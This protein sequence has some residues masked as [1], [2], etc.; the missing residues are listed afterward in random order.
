VGARTGVPIDVDLVVSRLGPPLEWEMAHW[1]PAERVP[2]VADLYRALYPTHAITPS[3]ALPGAAEAVRAVRDSGGQVVVVTAKMA[4]L[5]RLHLA[6]L[7]ITVT[8][9]Y[10]SAWADGKAEVLRTTAALAFVGD[11]T[12]DMAAARAAGVLGVGVLTGPA[13]A[14]QLAQAGA[15]VVLDDLRGFP[16][17]LA[18]IQLGRRV[19]GG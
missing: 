16:A 9:V 3:P 13:S 8:E 6:H 11:H 2:E 7:D 14:S 10:G 1:Y 18:E 15:D 5:A 19:S 17:W 12:A 4:E